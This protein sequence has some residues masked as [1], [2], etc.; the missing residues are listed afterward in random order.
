MRMRTVCL[1][2]G[3]A[4]PERSI[5][6]RVPAIGSRIA[7]KWNPM[8]T[9]NILTGHSK[10]WLARIVPIWSISRLPEVEVGVVGVYYIA[11]E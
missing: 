6:D 5:C 9:F 11:Y 3:L 2:V 10:S 4:T 8:T 1:I 7:F